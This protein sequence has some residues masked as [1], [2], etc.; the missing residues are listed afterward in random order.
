MCGKTGL[1]LILFIFFGIT[2]YS[3]ITITKEEVEQ[4]NVVGTTSTSY[5]D[6]TTT[7]AD[8]GITTGENSWDFSGFTSIQSFTNT[9]IDPATSPYHSSFPNSTICRK[10][11]VNIM[12]FESNNWLYNSID[13]NSFYL[14]GIVTSTSFIITIVST[15]TYSPSEIQIKFPLTTGT[16]WTQDYT[17]TTT[18]STGGTPAV[19]NY[20]LTYTVDAYGSLKLPGGIITQALRMKRDEIS[21]SGQNYDHQ[22]GYVFMTELG[23]SVSVSAADTL[24]PDHGT[25]N[26]YGAGWVLGNVTGTEDADNSQ[27]QN[28][29]LSQNYP[30]PFNPS[31]TIDYQLS[32]S[33][34]VKLIVYNSL[35]ETVA[36]LVN[37]YKPAGNYSVHF[38][39]SSSDHTMASGIYLYKLNAGNYSVIKKM[40]M[41]K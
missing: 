33:N 38:N 2:G 31:T 39:T 34:Y 22:I 1:I 13:L 37:E 26:I 28:F 23:S 15:T 27:P 25:I 21:I 11:T 18:S 4:Y 8:I 17:S 20:H 24:Q 12:G 29:E 35:G 10:Y 9:C 41:L 6:T 36:E 30:N 40:I 5:L 32:E 3:Q 16:S 19:T 7:S 14:D